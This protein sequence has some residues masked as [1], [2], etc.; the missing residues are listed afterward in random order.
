L[1]LFQVDQK[2]LHCT[3]QSQQPVCR[4][5]ACCFGLNLRLV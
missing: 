4:R 3:W 2:C 5:R 1:A